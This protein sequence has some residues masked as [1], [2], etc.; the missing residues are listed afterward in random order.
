MNRK[1]VTLFSSFFLVIYSFTA[2]GRNPLSPDTQSFA[3]DSQYVYIKS[4]DFRYH[5]DVL[6][7]I[8]E[9]SIRAFIRELKDKQ[10][11]NYKFVVFRRQN[12]QGVI[13]VNPD[14]TLAS[15]RESI[16]AQERKYAPTNFEYYPL[17]QHCCLKEL[18]NDSTV[19]ILTRISMPS[20]G[21]II[22]NL[23][24]LIP[25]N[26]NERKPML[27]FRYNRL[28]IDYTY[29]LGLKDADNG[30]N[31]I[32]N[33]I[34][35]LTQDLKR[36]Y[37]PPKHPRDIKMISNVH[38]NFVWKIYKVNQSPSKEITLKDLSQ[39]NNVYELFSSL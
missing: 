11:E 20:P 26:L 22:L 33:N 37:T 35:S 5:N 1:I 12:S 14:T 38:K 15:Q 28:S 19:L 7:N 16:E 21:E 24:S 36:F 25:N 29:T 10:N 18:I 39:F 23:T 2:I 17:Y 6:D 8:Y 13:K 4:L 9:A 27:P 32:Y 34:T 31:A 3:L 30:M